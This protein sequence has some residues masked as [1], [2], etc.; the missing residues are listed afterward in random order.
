[1]MTK[2]TEDRKEDISEDIQDTPV[3]SSDALQQEITVP[4]RELIVTPMITPQ[5]AKIAWQ[6]YQE[7]CRAILD[8]SDFVQIPRFV[9]GKGMLTT[10]FKL[11]SAW[12]KLATAFNLSSE[13]I[14]EE[15]VD[16]EKYFVV[17]IVVRTTAP[18]GRFVD[19]TGACA[20][21][22]RNFAHVEHDVR[23]QAETRAKN[24]SISDMIGGGEVS[25]EEMLQ[26]EE[27]KKEACPR[28]H[29]AL[30]PKVS[31]TEGKNKGRSY[32][33]CTLC[34]WGKWVDTGEVWNAG[35]KKET[36]TPIKEGS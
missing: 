35:K 5:A 22:E 30:E 8:T 34:Y 12:R 4:L 26:M 18:N 10:P 1:M 24:R 9:K 3:T 23:A 32:V 33:R 6:S 2:Q 25:A 21:N 15:R 28:D 17:K 14:K 27:E 7:L 13:V 31:K 11:K 19:G 16:Y 20:S 36:S 29:D